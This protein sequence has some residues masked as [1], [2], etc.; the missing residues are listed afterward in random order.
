M[1]GELASKA[2]QRPLARIGDLEERVE[3]RQL[4]QGLE[5]VV[6]VGQPQLTTL[7]AD[8]LGQRDE[9]AKT[10]AVDVTGLRKVDQELLF[11]ALELI[12]HLLLELLP[13]SDDQ[14]TFHIHH[15]HLPFLLHR[16]AHD[17]LSWRSS[18]GAAVASIDW[19][20]VMAAT[21]IMS[22]AVAPRERSLHGRRSPCTIGPIA[23]APARRCTSL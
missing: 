11:P 13:I 17:V 9:N 6:E 8:F 23:S 18:F 5:V 20:A 16:E 12:E 4:E 7:L 2:L 10:G 21:L 14:L 1:R 19:S 15:D 22:S 3:L